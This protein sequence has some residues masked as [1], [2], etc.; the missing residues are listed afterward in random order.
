MCETYCAARGLVGGAVGGHLSPETRRARNCRAGR[1][2]NCAPDDK[3]RAKERT[4][5]RTSSPPARLS[6]RAHLPK[7]STASK[8]DAPRSLERTREPCRL[9]PSWEHARNSPPQR[10]PRV[11]FLAEGPEVPILAGFLGLMPWWAS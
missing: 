7:Q 8:Q 11:A 5:P 3:A 1:L 10:W 4:G 6:K 2:P 9:M